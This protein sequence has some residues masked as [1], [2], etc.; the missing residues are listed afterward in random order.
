VPFRIVRDTMNIRKWV[1]TADWNERN[2]YN[3]TIPAGVFTNVAGERNDSLGANFKIAQ[4]SKFATLVVNVSGKTP[5]SKYILQIVNEGGVAQK[6]LKDVATGTYNFYYL[7]EGEV[8]LR[9]TEDGNGNGKWDTGNLVERRQPERT[10]FYVNAAGD[11]IIPLQTGW[12]V[13]LNVKMA[14]IFAPISIEKI[15]FDLGRA[16][17]AR[18][19]KYLEEK[20]KRDEERLRQE[21][22]SGGQGGGGLGIGGALG[23]AKGQIQS[24]VGGMGSGSGFGGGMNGMGGGMGY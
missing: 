8:R 14:D 12:D 22:Q 13:D 16:E 23:G 11:Q 9:I 15:R 24:T 3:L 19:A 18:V 20:A 5:E 7:A 2:G 21:R 10:E 6:E 1:I 4:R 17:D